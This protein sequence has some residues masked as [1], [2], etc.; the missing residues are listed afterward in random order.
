LKW[1]AALLLCL[2]VLSAFDFFKDPWYH[3]ENVNFWEWAK[4]EL[5]EEFSHE[6][7]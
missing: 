1:L 7:E 3:R 4:R 2:F 6:R 5:V